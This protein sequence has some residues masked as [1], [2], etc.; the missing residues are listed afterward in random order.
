M[1][2]SYHLMIL[3]AARKNLGF[4]LKILASIKTLVVPLNQAIFSFLFFIMLIT[5][6]MRMN[7]FQ[8]N[9]II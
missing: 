5:D 2:R 3:I 7:F 9:P 6:K 4:Q 8:V 1:F